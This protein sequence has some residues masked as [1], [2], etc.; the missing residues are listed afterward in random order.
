MKTH[1]YCAKCE[2]HL[3]ERSGPDINKV[4]RSCG[5]LLRILEHDPVERKE[6]EDN[7]LET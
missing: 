5:G 2:N 6:G 4:H 7:I 3:I 1:Y